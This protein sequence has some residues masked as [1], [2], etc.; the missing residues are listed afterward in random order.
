MNKMKIAVIAGLDSS[1]AEVSLRSAAQVYAALDRD[2]FEPYSITIKGSEWKAENP[3]GST[4]ID[5]NDFSFTDSTG[6]YLKLDYALIMIHGVPG[7]NGILQGYFELMGIPY[8]S[9]NV[10]ASALTFNKSLCKQAVSCVKNLNLAQEIKIHTGD[11]IN[12]QRYIDELGLPLFVK[13]NASGSSCGVTKVK[14][15]EQIQDAI[16]TAMKE[17]D[18]VLLEQYIEGVEVS[19]GVMV[20]GDRDYTLPITELATTNDFFDYQ[21]KYTPGVTQEITPARIDPQTTATLN[22]ITLD[23]YKTLGCTGIVRVDYIIKQGKA[24]FIEVNT[25]PGMSANSIVPQQLHAAGYTMQQAYTM[26]ITKKP[27]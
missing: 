21:A 5:K 25:V 2:L 11:P 12:P 23:V 4:A 20:I 16:D 8:S 7:E 22:Q 27:Q 13:P 18:T 6:R 26:I 3:D 19:Q 10:E 9:C 1:E 15:I 14:S 24:Y 17:S